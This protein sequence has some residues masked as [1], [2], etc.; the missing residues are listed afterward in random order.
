[1]IKILSKAILK[2]KGLILAVM[3]CQVHPNGETK[4][5]EHGVVGHI[6][7]QKEDSYEHMHDSAGPI[8]YKV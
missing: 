2:E 3:L 7:P 1:M 8:F 5:V 4:A 6:R